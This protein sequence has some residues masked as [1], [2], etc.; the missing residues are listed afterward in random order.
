MLEKNCLYQIQPLSLKIRDS[1][2]KKDIILNQD[3]VVK[4][5]EFSGINVKIK[6]LDTGEIFEVSKQGLNFSVEKI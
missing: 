2:S 1:I 6:R 5:L 3:E 4:V